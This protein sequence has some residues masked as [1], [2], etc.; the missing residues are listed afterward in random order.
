MCYPIVKKCL[1]PMFCLAAFVLG[2]SACGAKKAVEQA[3]VPNP[4]CTL[5]GG[6]QYVQ[7]T[8]AVSPNACSKLMFA[9]YKVAGFTVV[10]ANIVANAAD[11][12]RDALLGD[13]FQTQIVGKGTARVTEFTNNLAA[14]LIDAYG[15]ET[16]PGYIAYGGPIMKVAHSTLNITVAQY[17]YFL[18]SIVIP[19]LQQAGVAQSDIDNCFAPVVTDPNFIV[20]VVA[21]K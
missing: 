17:D 21:C 11:A 1:I 12:S 10:N 2:A 5:A 15:N 4:Q 14:F 8:K 7:D 16:D 9:K 13:S 3:V 20:Q 19:A 6:T 18:M